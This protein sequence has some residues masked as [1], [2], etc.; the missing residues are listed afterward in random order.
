MRKFLEFIKSKWLIKGTTTVL[1]VAIIIACYTAINWA[2]A[3]LNVE[4]LD[5][6]TNKLYSLSDETK[7]KIKDLKKEVTIQI[8]NYVDYPYISEFA[9]K[10]ASI[11]DKIKVEEIKDLASR[12]DL[13]QKYQLTETGNLIVIKCGDKEE[14]LDG[15]DL[16][17]YD[18]TMDGSVDR[19]EEAITNAIVEIVL[20]EKPVVY[21]LKGKAYNDPNQTMTILAT[22]IINESNELNS[23]DILTD[24]K[25][26][27]DCDCLIITTL[28]E[29]LTELERD[30]I[31]EYINNGG[32]IFML[33]SQNTLDFATPNFDKVLAAYGI[34]RE[35]GIIMEQDSSK[36]LYDTP[37]MIVESFNSSYMTSSNMA[38]EIFLINAGK[39]E[40]AEA[41][42]LEELGVTYEVLASTSNKA[43]VRT[44]FDIDS[45]TRTEQDSEE[46]SFIVGAKATKSVANDK[47]SELIIF[48]NETFASDSTI[49][50]GLQPVYTFGLR[51]NHDII[52]NSVAHLV[53]REDI[54][55]IRKTNETQNYI[56]TDQEDVIIK[57][58]IFVLPIFVI[59]TGIVVWYLRRRKS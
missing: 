45:L 43:F 32:K 4:S 52:L 59:G 47:K 23:V 56:V 33:T 5:F 50:I 22:E 44:K 12:V 29:D 35:Y 27:D 40:F 20:D 3:Q 36:M 30:K 9:Y 51:N 2:V 39:I 21:M 42:K 1:L 31:L 19:T 11:T 46:G 14:T 6:T 37:N 18:Y 13:Q 55:I 38:F 15:N 57:T 17:T 34:T 7:N 49:V 58:I 24:G 41:E 54:I 53:E 28:K 8:I 48:T 10:Y 26:P 25:I 16:Y